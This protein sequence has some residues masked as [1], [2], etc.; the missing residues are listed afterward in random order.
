MSGMFNI[1]KPVKKPEP[2]PEVDSKLSQLD[3]V[4]D[5]AGFPSRQ[6]PRRRKNYVGP[7]VA[8]NTKMPQHEFDRLVE[9]CQARGYTYRQAITRLLDIADQYDKG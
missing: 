4:A 9:Y 3:E 8:F 5:K 6:P 7:T 2:Q 1:K